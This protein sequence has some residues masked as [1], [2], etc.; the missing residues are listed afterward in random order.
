[1]KCCPSSLDYSCYARVAVLPSL[2]SLLLQ[3]LPPL[4]V[5]PL[6]AD[7]WP[8]RCPALARCAPPHPLWPSRFSSNA[9]GKCVVSA[10]Q[11]TLGTLT[12]GTFACPL[13]RR[14]AASGEGSLAR[15]RGLRCPASNTQHEWF[16]STARQCPGYRDLNQCPEC[17]PFSVPV[18]F[19]ARG[20][21]DDPVHRMRE[22]MK[23]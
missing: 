22:V 2:Q 12:A 13:R 1:M 9:R 4:P 23:S 3:L 6:R 7:R 20:S 18:T 11:V 10:T 17:I 5:S 16:R 15:L 19:T 14:E 8:L 21:R